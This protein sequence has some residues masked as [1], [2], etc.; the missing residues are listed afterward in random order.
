VEFTLRDFRRN[1]FETLWRIDQKCFA[2]GIA[3]SR[4]E[5]AAYIRRRGAFTLIAEPIVGNDSSRPGDPS[6][7]SEPVHPV[8]GFIVAEA[9]RRRFGHI[10]T[11]DVPPSSRRLGVGSKLLT[12]AEDRLRSALCPVVILETAVDNATALAFYKRNRYDIVKT[13]PRY[14][15]NGLDAFVLE[16]ELLPHR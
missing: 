8:L 4:M 11:I 10:L 13:I 12:T 16:K 6:P 3:Y 14:Y 9:D 7:D 1:D 15:P 2:P 5:L